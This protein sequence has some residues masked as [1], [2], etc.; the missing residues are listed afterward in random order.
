MVLTCLCILNLLEVYAAVRCILC[1]V[2][3]LVLLKVFQLK[4]ELVCT[5]C[6]ACH[7]FRR[8]NNRFCF[9]CNCDRIIKFK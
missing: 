7:L 6:C 2:D 4:L 3:H 8:R 9:L 5:Q 1:T